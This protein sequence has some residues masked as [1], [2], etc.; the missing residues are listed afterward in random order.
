LEDKERQ[1]ER[2][3]KKRKKPE[4]QEAETSNLFFMNNTSFNKLLKSDQVLSLGGP[5][6]VWYFLLF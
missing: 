6:G 4:K 2:R 1:K 5:F 3:K